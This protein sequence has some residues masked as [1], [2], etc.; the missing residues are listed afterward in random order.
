MV[1]SILHSCL[2]LSSAPVPD[3]ELMTPYMEGSQTPI[4]WAP[5]GE[6]I[7]YSS[8]EDKD[9]RM[10]VSSGLMLEPSTDDT[11]GDQDL[12]SPTEDLLLYVEQI[13]QMT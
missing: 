5:E 9:H 7:I 10:I 6:S 12:V 4:Q 11:V 8:E 3:T 13:V 1:Q 2:E